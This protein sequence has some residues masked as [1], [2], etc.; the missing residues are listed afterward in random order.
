MRTVQELLGPA[1]VSTTMVSTRGSFQFG[2][3]TR[4]CFAAIRGE[5]AETLQA[6]RLMSERVSC[7]PC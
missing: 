5:I 1:D 2:P 6:W 3:H 7:E 4:E